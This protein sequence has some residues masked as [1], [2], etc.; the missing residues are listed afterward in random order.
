MRWYQTIPDTDCEPAFEKSTSIP[1]I[2]V[3]LLVCLRPV[4]PLRGNMQRRESVTLF[5]HQ[6]HQQRSPHP[7]SLTG[8][9]PTGTTVGSYFHHH[10]HHA[11][12]P[13]DQER[14]I[15]QIGLSSSRLRR[16][17]Q[18]VVKRGALLSRVGKCIERVLALRCLARGV[19]TPWRPLPALQY[20]RNGRTWP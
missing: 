9:L 3:V 17:L 14:T 4:A 15:N 11:R 10:L 2:S 19:I 18:W 1:S 16:V 8:S 7:T 20:A 12:Q 13:S 5:H 6:S